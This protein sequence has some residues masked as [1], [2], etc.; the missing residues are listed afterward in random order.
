M[1]RLPWCLGGPLWALHQ[2]PEEHAW[3]LWF[4]AA[5]GLCTSQQG[6]D[7]QTA[8]G[9]EHSRVRG[10]SQGGRPTSSCS[11]SSHTLSCTTPRARH[12][13]GRPGA[14]S[15]QH[16]CMRVP[17]CAISLLHACVCL[18]VLS[19]V[20]KGQAR[21]IRRPRARRT[22]TGA[23][24]GAGAG[25]GAGGA[26][27][28]SPRAGLD[29]KLDPARVVPMTPGSPAPMTPAHLQGGSAVGK[30]CSA[31]AACALM[32]GI[33]RAEPLSSLCFGLS[34]ARVSGCF[35]IFHVTVVPPP[36]W[37]Q[38]LQAVPPLLG[39]CPPVALQP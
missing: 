3:G 33:G 34:C 15:F 16:A 18:L 14:I 1:C 13:P 4:Q 17:A 12:V 21:V 27:G 32:D 39:I 10:G 28:V 23:K 30:R 7:N 22:R 5:R 36:P 25:A 35:S 6:R 24:L 8:G 9:A 11:I 31:S 26:A 29:T 37:L 38:A 2:H 19:Q 20:L